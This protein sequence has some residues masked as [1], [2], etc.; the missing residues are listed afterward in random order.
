MEAVDVLKGAVSTIDTAVTVLGY[1]KK[2]GVNSTGEV[3]QEITTIPKEVFI[4]LQKSMVFLRIGGLS[5]AVAVS[6][7]M[8]GTHAFKY[9]DKN[10]NQ[11]QKIYEN[12]YKMHL[13]HSVALTCAD[14]CNK[15]LTGSLFTLG[16]LLYS[17]SCYAHGLSGN[18]KFGIITYFGEVVLISAWFS[19]LIN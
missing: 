5:G 13:L 17:G 18:A 6:M 3:K 16:I 11:L 19:M 4:P 1:E 10:W 12:G 9:R 15:P 14:L 8:Y 2:V 7:A